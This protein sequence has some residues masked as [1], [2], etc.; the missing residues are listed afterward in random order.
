MILIPVDP[1]AAFDALSIL[2][3]KVRH[4][5]A[6]ICMVDVMETIISSQIGEDKLADIC[7][8]KEWEALLESNDSHFDLEEKA[9]AGGI[10]HS[11]I[12]ESNMRRYRAKAAL[13]KAHF[14]GDQMVEQKSM[15]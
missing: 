12:R 15:T 9:I 11:E 10:D 13:Q 5:L 1:G 14:P 8:S 2:I 6:D 7:D 4:K 3:T